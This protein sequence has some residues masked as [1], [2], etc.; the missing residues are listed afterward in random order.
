MTVFCYFKTIRLRYVIFTGSR[1]SFHGG[2][3]V[4]VCLNLGLA[5]TVGG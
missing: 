2:G 3:T 4:I 5:N 1:K